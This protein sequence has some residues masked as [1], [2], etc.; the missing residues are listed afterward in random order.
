MFASAPLYGG[1]LVG[2][3]PDFVRRAFPETRTATQAALQFVRSTANVTSAV[4]GMR[5]AEHVEENLF[6]A[7]VPRA[8]AQLPSRLFAAAARADSAQA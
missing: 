6:L 5:E 8:P 2:R 3:V 7:S 1:R 4:V